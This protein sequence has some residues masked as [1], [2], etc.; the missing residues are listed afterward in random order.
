VGLKPPELVPERAFAKGSLA[1]FLPFNLKTSPRC[2][3]AVDAVGCHMTNNHK[4][5]N[6]QLTAL[7]TPLPQTGEGLID[8][9]PQ[10]SSCTAS[11]RRHRCRERRLF[12]C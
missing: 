8:V 10:S 6:Q 2:R 11:D 9:Q 7:G 5:Q 3:F 4:S 1:A 12:G